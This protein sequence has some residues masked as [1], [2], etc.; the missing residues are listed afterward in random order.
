MEAWAGPVGEEDGA[1]DNGLSTDT[2][3]F[4]LGHPWDPNRR[5]LAADHP[6][7]RRHLVKWCPR[8]VA[9]LGSALRSGRRGRRF[10][11]CHPDFHFPGPGR[12]PLGVNRNP[13]CS[14]VWLL[15]TNTSVNMS[16]DSSGN[17]ARV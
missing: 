15:P 14:R 3:E 4:K 6:E 1:V 5:P 16:T 10:E 12:Y 2:A 8:D 7:T 11:S 9:Q 17:V 13:S